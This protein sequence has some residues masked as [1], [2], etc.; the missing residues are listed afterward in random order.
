[1]LFWL[2]VDV[3]SI[4]LCVVTVYCTVLGRSHRGDVQSR[5]FDPEPG[6]GHR[7][8]D[9]VDVTALQT[10]GPLGSASGSRRTETP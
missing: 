4:F 6:W 7:V 5:G 9:A 1:M 10:G 2:W 8:S 3:Q